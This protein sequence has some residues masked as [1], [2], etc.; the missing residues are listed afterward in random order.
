VEAVSGFVTRAPIVFAA[1]V[2]AAALS[3]ASARPAHAAV[4]LGVY[5]AAQGQA[6]APEDAGVMDDYAAMVGRK[7]DIVMDYSNVT[8]PLLTQ[9]EIANLQARGETPMVTWQLYRSGWGGPTISLRE[10][11]A[12]SYDSYLHA[13]ADLARHLPFTVMIRFAHEMNGDWYPWSGDPAAYVQA[14]RHVVSVFRQDGATNVK[15][16]WAPNVD[17]GSYPF[18]S[19]FPGDQ[20]VDYVAL[21]GYND[22]TASFG[23]D[24][25]ESLYQVFASSYAQVTRL[26]AKP[27]IISEVASSEAGGDKAAWIRE[28]FLSTIP[29]RFPRVA[30]VVWFDRDQEEDWRIDSSAASL[31]AY[32]EV[33]AS[34][35]YGG[36]A[37]A[38]ARPNAVR[39]AAAARVLALSVTAAQGLRAA[40]SAKRSSGAARSGRIAYRLSRRAGLRIL[41]RALGR[42]GLTFA[43][44]LR[45]APRAG[46]LALL[47]ATRGRP[48]PRGAYRATAVAIGR[49]G[50]QSRPFSTIFV[51]GPA[52]G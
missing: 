27:V 37:Q 10:I 4:K 39:D 48:L 52:R 41:V 45:R 9:V 44:T 18:A 51:I 19:Y 32:R 7:P 40:R 30:A 36:P 28:G 2:S 16:V 6:G 14:W 21:D 34:S 8:D 31:Q 1:L 15:W 29:Q 42:R 50:L 46:F 38:P 13:A 22:G 33:V 20:W 23:V 26:S 17:N 3:L 5:V 49:G 12:G 24:R 25:W 35:L 47:Q 11:A 43:I